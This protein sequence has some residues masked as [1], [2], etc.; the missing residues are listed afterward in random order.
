MSDL[1]LNADK[2]PIDDKCYEE[3]GHFG[4]NNMY[5][6]LRC[7]TVF[8]PNYKNIELILGCVKSC[9]N[10][11]Y[12]NV[13]I[14]VIDNGFN[15][16]GDLLR[17]ELAKFKDERIIYRPNTSNIGCQGNFSLLL[18][19]AQDTSRFILIPADVYLAK[20]CIQKMVAAAEKTPSANIIY[21]RSIS[22]DIMRSE[23]AADINVEDNLLPWPHRNR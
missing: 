6:S 17:K 9:L 20:E 4:N 18:S 23:L 10:Q 5:D 8:I 2:N 15:E 21:P 7:V 1:A 11:S 12:K 3:V 16:C 22:R 14:V 19:L 13:R